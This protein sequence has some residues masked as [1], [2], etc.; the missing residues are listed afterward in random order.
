MSTTAN[1]LHQPTLKIFDRGSLKPTFTKKSSLDRIS[2]KSSVFGAGFVSRNMT[3]LIKTSAFRNGSSS[4]NIEEDVNVFEQ[5]ALVDGSSKLVASGLEST[6]NRLSKWLVSGLFSVII[7]WRHDSEALW[8]TM[9]S[10]INSALA[11]V[12]KRI[13]NQERPVPTLKSDPGMPSSHAQSIFFIG[14]F[15]ILSSN[16]FLPFIPLKGAGVGC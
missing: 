2:I 8:A 10:V 1:I 9:G 11:M 15:I 16:S 13:L 4:S 3:E 5:E 14:G 12:L 6:I 7:I